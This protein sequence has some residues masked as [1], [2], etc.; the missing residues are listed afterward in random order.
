MP[1]APP[2]VIKA[3]FNLTLPKKGGAKGDFIPVL[4]L[5]GQW[6]VTRLAGLSSRLVS[7]LKK[8]DKVR[9]TGEGLEALDTAGAFTLRQAVADKLDGD[10][11][12]DNENYARIYAL[13]T[14]CKG[15]VDAYEQDNP[16]KQKFWLHPVYYVLEHL[17]RIMSAFGRGFINQS[18]FMGHVITLWMLSIVR[19][20]RVPL[21]GV[22][23]HHAAC[24]A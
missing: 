15:D 21:G 3:D 5:T 13:V 14:T 6:I 2:P 24:R 18:V 23:Q 10:I 1:K 16:S 20:S 7:A 19:P 17:G 4:N 11:F 12:T 9:I 8:H 22:V